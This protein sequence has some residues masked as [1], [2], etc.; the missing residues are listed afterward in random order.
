MKS[1]EE[2]IKINSDIAKRYSA[3]REAVETL[4][5]LAQEKCSKRLLDLANRAM[6]EL[7]KI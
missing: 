5:A 2:I 1:L 3:L 4:G 7:E 6:D